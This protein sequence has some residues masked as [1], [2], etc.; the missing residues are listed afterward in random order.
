[1]WT[2][3]RTSESDTPN[4]F[5][6]QTPK[7]C[8]A[9]SNKSVKFRKLLEIFMDFKSL[10]FG[11]YKRFWVP[12]DEVS[13]SEAYQAI[14]KHTEFFSA[15]CLGKFLVWTVIENRMAQCLASI[16]HSG[17]FESFSSVLF[18]VVLYSNYSTFT[19]PLLFRITI[20]LL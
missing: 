7:P 8:I 3:A 19:L 6:R 15:T 1:M 10:V 2:P 12:P 20:F 11:Q 4:I 16:F 18:F 9:L 5:T 13:F 14:S 17:Q